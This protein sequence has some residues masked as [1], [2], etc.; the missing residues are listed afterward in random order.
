MAKININLNN[1][2]YSIDESTLDTATAELKSHLSIT[3][4]GTGAAISLGGIAYNVDSAKLSAA[5]NDFTSHLSTISGSGFKVAIGGVEY[6]VD[7]T[8]VSSAFDE[9]E[10]TLGDLSS[11]TLE[12]IFFDGNTEGL[13]T[14]SLGGLTAY[15]VSS[16]PVAWDELIG[17][18]ITYGKR[19]DL[20]LDNPVES[21]ILVEESL[22]DMSANINLPE[23]TLFCD[24]SGE[25]FLVA[26]EDILISPVSVKRGIYATSG[27]PFSITFPS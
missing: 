23:H 3:M 21:G 1:K 11:S 24:M 17:A 20:D 18:T 27:R 12:P 4:N 7:S 10:S 16:E 25:I 9:L 26:M 13:E 6:S 14:G 5:Q 19:G 22:Y 15:R 2:T 8:N